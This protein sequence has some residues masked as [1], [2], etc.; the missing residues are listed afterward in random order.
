[1]GL[2]SGL[3][4]VTMYIPISSPRTQ[5]QVE[6]EIGAKVAGALRQAHSILAPVVT[7]SFS[8]RMACDWGC[9]ATSG[10]VYS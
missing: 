9:L 10:I 2:A 1:M 5:L 7:I 6:V 3:G 8:G 4:L